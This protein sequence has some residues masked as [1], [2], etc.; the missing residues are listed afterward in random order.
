MG[1]KIENAYLDSLKKERKTRK[2]QL[3]ALVKAIMNGLDVTTIH[4]Q[5]LEL[6]NNIKYLEEQI[7]F[8][9]AKQNK[10]LD[11][12]E[13]I[14]Y[15]TNFLNTNKASEHFNKLVL[16]TLVNKILLYPNKLVIVL[17]ITSD[18]RSPLTEDETALID[19]NGNLPPH[20]RNSK[21]INDRSPI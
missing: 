14:S 4:D 18:D 10:C 12:D 19:A 5:V 11:K 15:I 3:D 2:K 16:N 8:E 21:L 17:N 20:C 1:Q 9:E 6:E 7:E 13:M